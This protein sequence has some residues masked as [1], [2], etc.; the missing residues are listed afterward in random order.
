MRSA[1]FICSP[2]RQAVT[3]G[4][5]ACSAS[6][7]SEAGEAAGLGRRRAGCVV[8]LRAAEP[9]PAKRQEE[10]GPRQQRCPALSAV[11]QRQL[12]N[13][14]VLAVARYLQDRIAELWPY[15]RGPAPSDTEPRAAAPA[16]ST[17]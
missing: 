15:D 6:A 5:T 16:T 2:G 4:V 9:E 14:A 7:R 17:S 11:P 10:A 8:T 12:D 13:S 3:S 1:N